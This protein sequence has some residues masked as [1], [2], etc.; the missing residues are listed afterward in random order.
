MKAS[1]NWLK[2]FV[3]FKEMPEELAHIL[4]MAGLEVELIE[5]A[6]ND[7][8]F[9][10]GVTPNRSDWLSMRGIARE[11][12]AILNLPMK[13]I[14]ASITNEIGEGPVVEIEDAALCPRYSSRIIKGVKPGP[15]PEWLSKKLESCGI[16]PT[17]NIVDITNYV[18]LEIGQP[19]HAFDLDK[20]AGKKIIVKQAG[21][22]NKFTTLDGEERKISKETLLIWDVEKPV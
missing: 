13:D 21:D 8:I 10:I 14:T 18:L 22:A 11:I 20:L 6:G 2:E 12:S 4:T 5:K 3:D 15:S 17:S 19:M 16:R 1:Y 7:I 9:D